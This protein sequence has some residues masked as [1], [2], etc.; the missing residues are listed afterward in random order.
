MPRVA[1]G[2]K[3]EASALIWRKIATESDQKKLP[4]VAIKSQ[5]AD[6]RLLEGALMKKASPEPR[7]IMAVMMSEMVST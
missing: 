7:A 3:S 6:R 4:I 1:T 2:A 5:K